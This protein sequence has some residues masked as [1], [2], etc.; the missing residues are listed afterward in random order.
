MSIHKLNQPLE[1]R[2]QRTVKQQ[3]ERIRGAAELY[4]KQFLNEMVKA[5]RKTVSHGKL[6][7]PTMAE[8]IYRERLDHKYVDE[9]TK[10][11]GVGLTDLIY[12]QIKDRY[13]NRNVGGPVKKLI[14][15]PK[16]KSPMLPIEKL[17]SFPIQ[18][19]RELGYLFFPE[20]NESSEIVSP[21]Q[22]KLLQA[23]SL[24]GG[25]QSIKIDHSDIGIISHLS[26]VGPKF[27]GKEFV[28][29][30][31]VGR[32]FN[33]P[34]D[35]GTGQKLGHLLNSDSALTWILTSTGTSSPESVNLAG[36]SV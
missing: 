29:K 11:G 3:N 10:S 31:F 32:K 15:I 20:K 7:K 9:W 23:I 8:K 22:G 21:W 4:E 35:I 12:R 19:S 26:F 6:T 18:N 14:P 13:Y 1:I 34:K 36:D 28:G 33:V 25:R 17:K 5:M 24:D 30:D 2:P 27:V 16:P